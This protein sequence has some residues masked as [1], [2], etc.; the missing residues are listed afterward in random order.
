MRHAKHIPFLTCLL[1]SLLLASSALAQTGETRQTEL[2]KESTNSESI[3]AARSQYLNSATENIFR[4]TDA[5]I[6]NS[7][8]STRTSP[9]PFPPRHGYG[10]R[11]GYHR[12]PWMDHGGG[13]ALLGAVIGFG[14]G[15]AL[16]AATSTNRQPGTKVGAVVIFGGFGALIG[17]E[18]GEAHGGP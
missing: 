16:G 18:V 17:G 13:H 5:A 10:Y 7:Q 14:L 3:S 15:A 2:E 8:F 9:A 11:R 6:S 1:A 4:N 12:S